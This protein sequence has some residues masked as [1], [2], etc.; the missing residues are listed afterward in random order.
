MFKHN[1]TGVDPNQAF[2]V[3]PEGWYEFK[4]FD[5]MEKT[6]KS[7]NPM[8]ECICQVINDAQ[9]KGQEITHYVV[10]LPKEKK[11]AGISVHFRKAINEPFG[12][13]DIV[14]ADNW[15]GKR[16]RGYVVIEDYT[17]KE[18]KNAG[19]KFKQNKISEIEAPAEPNLSA[20]E[21]SVPF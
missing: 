20:E 1:S 17:P 21:S 9:W 3:M 6:S 19:K 15:K 14:N 10:F 12:G 7:N 16:F 4:I 18:G 11:G 5:A 2:P 13:D 8:I